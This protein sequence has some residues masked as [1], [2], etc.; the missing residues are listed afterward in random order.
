MGL[1]LGVLANVLG[2]STYYLLKEALESW[3]PAVLILARVL[4]AA[5][6]FAATMPRGW[7][8][9]STRAD[10]ARLFLI[11]LVG[12]AGPH[13]VGIYGL[14]DTDSMT[15]AILIGVEPIS[16][17]V[18]SWLFLGDRLTP[19]QGLAIAAAIL[20]GA[21]VVTGGDL[22]RAVD[23]G[24]SV[25]GS[26]LLAVHGVLWAVYTVAAKPTLVRAPP[27]ALAGVTALISLL[28]IAPAAALEWGELDL[29][30]ALQPK[31]IVLVLALSLG[32]TYGATVVWNAALR[33][34][35]PTQMASLIFLQPVT[36]ALLGATRGER[37][38]LASLAGAALILAAVF[39][40]RERAAKNE[41]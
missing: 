2:G 41:A 23:L 12:L 14:E 37:L 1:A 11:G 38:G 26:A 4:V 21:L 3:P 25:R 13:L 7:V 5:P 18:L 30:R 9:R 35:R 40:V 10:W 32:I 24:R 17:V 39:G 29:A 22:A 19:R 34:L 28:A 20:G 15:G 33:H 16:I 6:L 27:R 8:A 36:G 31:S